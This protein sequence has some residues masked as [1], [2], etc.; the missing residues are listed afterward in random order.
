TE[1]DVLRTPTSVLASARSSSALREFPE[2]PT[3]L[4]TIAPPRGR[5]WTLW[6][7]LPA[8]GAAAAIAALSLDRKD[9]P[10]S[11]AAVI[12]PGVA[13]PSDR[14][15]GGTSSGEETDTVKWMV[16]TEPRGAKVIIDGRPY[17]RTTPM[18]V[19]L[20]RSEAPVRVRLELAGYKP[21]EVE[22]A[23]LGNENHTYYLVPLTA[24][25]PAV[26]SALPNTSLHFSAKKPKPG[27]P[28]RTG[29]PAAG[30]QT[31]PQTPSV[32][33]Q[34]K[35]QPNPGGAGELADMPVFGGS[36]SRPPSG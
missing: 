14:L 17:E 35:P 32:D 27:K 21:H 19:E 4:N 7:L 36:K 9:V 23:P 16:Y 15:H 22:L 18:P 29:E 8:L 30:A 33:A 20:P 1:G 31:G 26:T 3:A 2:V 28:K 5:Q 12:D 13:L 10:V 11:P 34:P 6:V 25:T 24:A